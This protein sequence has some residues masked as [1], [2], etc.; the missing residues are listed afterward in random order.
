MDASPITG[1]L[2]AIS[3]DDSSLY[4]LDTNSAAPTLIGSLGTGFFNVPD[5]SFDPAGNLYGWSERSDD[6]Y[7]IDRLDRI[8]TIQPSGLRL[9]RR[10]AA[11]LGKA[12]VLPR[13]VP[14]WKTASS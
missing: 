8:M 13:P 4:R 12:I 5:M 10:D 7:S 14:E 1:E 6:L 2:Y 11:F 3:S 9:L